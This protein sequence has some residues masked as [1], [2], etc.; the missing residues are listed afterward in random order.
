MMGVKICGLCRP[1]DAAAAVAAGADYVGVILAPGMRRS[2][3]YQAAAQIFAAAAG[4][5]RVGVFVDPQA[6]EVNAAISELSLSVVQLHGQESPALVASLAQ[7]VTVWKAVRVRAPHELR[8]AA[9]H[10][11][12]AA[13]L[14]LDAYHPDLAGGSGARL[15]WAALVQDRNGLPADLQVVLAGGLTHHNVA[16]AI[17]WLAPHVVD[18]SSGV[19]RVVGEKSPELMIWFVTAAR[20]AENGSMHE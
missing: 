10:Y 3:S 16:A 19:E 5:R 13:A 14:L 7:S 8:D 6:Q 18:V 4:A 12:H 20:A 15:D 2:Q 1:D 11:P 9:N 17:R